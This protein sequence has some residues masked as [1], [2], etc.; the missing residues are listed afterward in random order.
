MAG[1]E[2]YILGVGHNTIVCIDLAEACGYKVIGLYHYNGERTGESYYGFPI[3][4]SNEDLL[5]ADSLKGNYFA[6]S[7]G[8]NPIRSDLSNRIRG[9]GGE[10][11]ALIHPNATVSKYAQVAE[12]VSIYPNSAIQPGTK[13]ER[14]TIIL[15]NVSVAHNTTIGKGCFAASG[16]IIGAYITIGDGAFIGQNATLISAKVNR[17]GQGA[18][19][20]AGSVVTKEVLPNQVVAG[21]PAKVIN[22]LER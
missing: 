5:R 20:G 11:P 4:G 22:R 1:Q 9:L 14:D 19:V 10:T 3:L 21:N 16:A 12:G 18:V 8:D 7:V 13:I 15:Y 6:I 2:I 17:I